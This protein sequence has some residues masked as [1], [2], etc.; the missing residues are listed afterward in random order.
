MGGWDGE[1][2]PVGEVVPVGKGLPVGEI[3]PVG[4]PQPSARLPP[5]SDDVVGASYVE[6]ERKSSA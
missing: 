5:S 3:V 6:M 1:G 4:D 2:L